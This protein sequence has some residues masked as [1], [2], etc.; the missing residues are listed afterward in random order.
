MQSVEGSFVTNTIYYLTCEN[1]ERHP[2][3]PEVE[4]LTLH[5][6]LICVVCGSS[7]MD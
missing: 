5:Q 1:C 6:D 7:A 2:D 3:Y 4:P